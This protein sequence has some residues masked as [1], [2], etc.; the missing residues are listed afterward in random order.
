MSDLSEQGFP[1]INRAYRDTFQPGQLTL[2]LVVPLEAHRH[3]AVPSLESLRIE[4]NFVWSRR[5]VI[6]AK[7]KMTLLPIILGQVLCLFPKELGP[8]QGR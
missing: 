8:F 4:R 7:H 6:I 1:E 3:S 2:G 5:A